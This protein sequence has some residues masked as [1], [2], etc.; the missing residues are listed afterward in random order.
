MNITEACKF[1]LIRQTSPTVYKQTNRPPSDPCSGIPF[2]MQVNG[3]RNL[4][5]I[6]N[7]FPNG[8]L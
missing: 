8:V 7:F 1:M 3:F 6:L 4:V 2:T 5:F